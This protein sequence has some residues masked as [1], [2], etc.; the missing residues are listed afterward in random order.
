VDRVSQ[1]LFP[2]D[3]DRVPAALVHRRAVPDS[4]GLDDPTL[5]VGDFILVNKFAYGIRL[6]IVKQEDHRRRRPPARRRDG[7]PLPEDPSLD[8]IKRVVGLPGDRIT[9]VNKRLSVNGKELDLKSAGDYLHKERMSFAKR[10]EETAG[11]HAH[12]ILIEDDAP[13]AV[14]FVKQFPFRE[15]CTYNNEGLTCNVRRDTTFSWA[16]TA[17]TRATAGYGV[18]PGCQH[19]GEGV[20]YLVQLQ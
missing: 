8:Y 12:S 1:E 4:F 16:T 3:T 18:R 20:L 11:E 6:P 14:P 19:R 15:N 9:Y 7:V 2:G 5:L 10:Y 17:T 13:A